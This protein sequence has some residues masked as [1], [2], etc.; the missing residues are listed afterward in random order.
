MEVKWAA[1]ILTCWLWSCSK[2]SPVP[3]NLHQQDY[4]L[5][6]FF[7]LIS[8]L[9]MFCLTEVTGSHLLMKVLQCS[10]RLSETPATHRASA[11]A[12]LSTSGLS[13]VRWFSKM[14]HQR[15]NVD[16]I[17]LTNT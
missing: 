12:I 10:L 15:S 9:I 4:Y 6:I 11:H 17:R 8:D 13:G 1:F 14:Q 3:I 16:A 5:F 2:Q 7:F